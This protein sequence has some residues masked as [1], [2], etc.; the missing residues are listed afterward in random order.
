[1]TKLTEITN[2][3]LN[4]A[5]G[6]L[7]YIVDVSDTTEGPAG[8]SGY[9]TPGDLLQTTAMSFAS[10]AAAAAATIPAGTTR[11]FAGGLAYV[12]D[13]SG[14]A[15]QSADGRKW[16]PDRIAIYEHWGAVGNGTTDDTV[17]IR[18]AHDWCMR[19]DVQLRPLGHTY[20]VSGTILDY[21]R[22]RDG[23]L[24]FNLIG[25]G[26]KRTT[27]SVTTALS[28]FLFKIVGNTGDFGASH[29]RFWTI[30]EIRVQ[31]NGNA[32]CD[33][34]QIDCADR[35]DLIRVAITNCRGYAVLG[36][37]WW[38]SRCD[39]VTT[40]C[41]DDGLGANSGSNGV[42]PVPAYQ[43]E[44]VRLDKYF[45]TPNTQGGSNNIYFPPTTQIEAMRWRAVYFGPATA[46][47]HFYGKIHGNQDITVTEP[48]ILLDGADSNLIIG[49]N[50]A[51]TD[52]VVIRLV[53][54]GG[55][56][57]NENIIIGNSFKFNSGNAVEIVG[58]RRNIVCGNHFRGAPGG[59]GV[60]VTG[61]SSSENQV[62]GNTV[63]NGV[64]EMSVEGDGMTA[65]LRVPFV[66]GF[67][68][69]GGGIDLR[70]PNGSL[71][72]LAVNSNGVLTLN[73]QPV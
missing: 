40:Q 45:G 60:L 16:S 5:A 43:K 33:V 29:G 7:L 4:P 42:T 41:G 25:D 13:V 14:T 11:L 9:T 59:F 17:A 22:A 69:P 66:L 35:V 36:R 34:F 51:A 6:D 31:S 15:L 52:S 26:R 44:A 19:N 53:A 21:N 50:F 54:N 24:T 63:S 10:R 70:A 12:E 73:G 49:C 2:R 68:R 62:V 46:K 48:H 37:E 71:H 30:Q 55:L 3:V 56:E 1:M 65:P 39:I 23:D 18:A 38:D 57:P 27:F 72:R 8:T 47:C 32:T 58:G 28:D 67:A 61:S 20:R 64:E